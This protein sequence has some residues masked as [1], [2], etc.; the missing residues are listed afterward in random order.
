M[1]CLG[2][3]CKKQEKNKM[4]KW[5]YFTIHRSH[6]S[7]AIHLNNYFIT[8]LQHRNMPRKAFHQNTKALGIFKAFFPYI[9]LG[10]LARHLVNPYYEPLLDS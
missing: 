8:H 10:V 7:Y 9:P 4:E 3:K 2:Y 1:S 5:A 6:E